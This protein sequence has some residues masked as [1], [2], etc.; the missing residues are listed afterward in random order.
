[1][2]RILRGLLKGSVSKNMHQAKNG[3]LALED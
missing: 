1:M 3:Q 2:R